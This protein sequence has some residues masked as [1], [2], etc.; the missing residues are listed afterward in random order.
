VAQRL[1]LS[2]AEVRD[3][4][5]A[6]ILHDIGKVAVP[7]QALN[8]REVEAEGPVELVDHELR[9]FG[10]LSPARE[11]RGQPRGELELLAQICHL[12]AAAHGSS[13]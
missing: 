8:S 9:H 11:S 7:V 13:P 10:D 6:A 2:D 12:V 5:Y 4:R 1:S 3:V